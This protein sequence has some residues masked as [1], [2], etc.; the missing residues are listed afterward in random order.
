MS[1]VSRASEM[2][3]FQVVY[4]V[5]CVE[6]RCFGLSIATSICTTEGAAKS[7]DPPVQ[8]LVKVLVLLLEHLE[9]GFDGDLVLAV[10]LEIPSLI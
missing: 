1:L 8:L 9:H 3:L 4:H 7:V 2:P 10:T 5:F 6:R